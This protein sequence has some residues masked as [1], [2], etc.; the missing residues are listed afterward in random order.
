MVLTPPPEKDGGHMRAPG[1]VGWEWP[2]GVGQEDDGVLRASGSVA[3]HSVVRAAMCKG[4]GIP[5][6]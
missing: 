4:R 3:Y 5:A 6:S 2:A 1:A